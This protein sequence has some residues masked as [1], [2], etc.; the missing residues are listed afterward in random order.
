MASGALESYFT[1]DVPDRRSVQSAVFAVLFSF[2]SVSHTLL[3]SQSRSE[4]RSRWKGMGGIR[5]SKVVC[6]PRG[7]NPAPGLDI[8]TWE[9]DDKGEQHLIPSVSLLTVVTR[10]P[11]PCK[12][13][14]TLGSP[15]APH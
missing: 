15:N 2:I 3:R 7:A 13:T 1:D 11:F 10:S 8:G 12:A 4:S 14:I 6:S 5:L 9:A